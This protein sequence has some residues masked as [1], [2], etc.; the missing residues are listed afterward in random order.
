MREEKSVYKAL[1]SEQEVELES[2]KVELGVADELA[3]LIKRGLSIEKKLSSQITSYN[4]LLR[5]GNGFKNKYAE[6]VKVAKEIGLPIP[7]EMKKFEDIAD[8]FIKKGEAL[9]KVSNLF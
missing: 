9:K 8:G 4:G 2:R 3:D 6:L 5:A 1:F 7:P